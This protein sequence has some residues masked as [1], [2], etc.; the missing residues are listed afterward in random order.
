MFIN[1]HYKDCPPKGGDMGWKYIFTYR[2]TADVYG[3]SNQRKTVN[4]DTR[5]TIITY[6]IGKRLRERVGQLA[7]YN[8]LSQAA[9]NEV[10]NNQME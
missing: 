2:Y 5:R 4:R 7:C 6:T 1:D 8:L 10:F 9:T 3:K